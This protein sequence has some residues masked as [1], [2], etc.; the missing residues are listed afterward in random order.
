MTDPK[1]GG[2]PGGA[3]KGSIGPPASIPSGAVKAAVGT[4]GFRFTSNGRRDKR[5]PLVEAL[6][7]V[8]CP[9]PCNGRSGP[10]NG[11]HDATCIPKAEEHVG[12]VL[13]LVAPAVRDAIEGPLVELLRELNSALWLHA[14]RYAIASSA[15]GRA[16]GVIA[17][18]NER[19]AA[20]RAAQGED[21]E[22]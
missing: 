11:W 19:S 17:R 22:K 8:A 3:P 18:Y 16:T 6:A 12:R 14:P 21:G 7:E 2:Y 15:T 4:T 10:D 5:D 13:S 20:V 1:R 9:P